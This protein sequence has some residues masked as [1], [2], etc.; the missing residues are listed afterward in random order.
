[1]PDFRRR[2]TQANPLVKVTPGDQSEDARCGYVSTQLGRCQF[3]GAVRAGFSGPFYCAEHRRHQIGPEAEQVAEVSLAKAPRRWDLKQGE[4]VDA[5]GQAET[6]PEEWE[7]VAQEVAR[8]HG[9]DPALRPRERAIAIA[10]KLGLVGAV[11]ELFQGARRT[12]HEK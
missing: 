3:W 2:K 4:L 7:I 9:V 6:S 1:M 11:G 12:P 10:R 5:A 8:T